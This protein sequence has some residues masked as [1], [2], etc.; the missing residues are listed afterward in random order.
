MEDIFRAWSNIVDDIKFESERLLDD[1]VIDNLEKLPKI[2][3][4]WFYDL[5]CRIRS[6]V[7]RLRVAA[8]DTTSA[9]LSGG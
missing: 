7:I 4:E 9:H 2:H 8:S 6:D 3:Q 1:R 5:L